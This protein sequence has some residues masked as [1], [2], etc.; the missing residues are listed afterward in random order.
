MEI[1]FKDMA[2]SLGTREVGRSIREKIEH[3]IS[4]GIITTLNL[5]DVGVVSN[6]FSDECFAKL[7][8]KHSLPE[9]KS[10]IKFK[11]ANPFVAKVIANSFRQRQEVLI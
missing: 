11:N 8:F 1:R 3:N 5:E 2:N 7:L 10:S 9:I 6:S 4:S